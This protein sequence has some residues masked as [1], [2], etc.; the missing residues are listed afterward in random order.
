MVVAA[1]KHMALNSAKLDK[2]E[3]VDIRIWKKKMHF[4]LSRISVVYVLTIPILE[5]GK[6][7]TMEQ[8]RKRNKLENNDYVCIGSHLYIEESFEVQDSDKQKSNNVASPLVVNMV[9][10]NSYIRYNDNKGKRKHQDIK[11][12]PNKKFKLTYWKCG[13]PE[14][15]LAL[16]YV[17]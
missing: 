8:I 3:G 7:A 1:I 6:N 14:H 11:A 12:D 16:K 4:L 17:G 13:K 10:H 9:E 5:D 15:L 2:F